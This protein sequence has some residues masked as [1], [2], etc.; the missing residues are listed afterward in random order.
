MSHV[1]IPT[2]YQ[3]KK[4][5]KK[6]ELPSTIIVHWNRTKP[7]PKSN[8]RINLALGSNHSM[9]FSRL[10]LISLQMNIKSAL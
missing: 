3:V 9:S 7:E 2:I 6:K 4:E 10:L 8:F 5:K 1:R